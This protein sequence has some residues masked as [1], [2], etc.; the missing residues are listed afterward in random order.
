MNEP[1]SANEVAKACTAPSGPGCGPSA[2]TAFLRDQDW[3]ILSGK[4]T[5]GLSLSTEL[6]IKKE[7]IEDRIP[8]PSKKG[9]RKRKSRKKKRKKTRHKYL[10]RKRG[11]THCKRKK[12]R[13]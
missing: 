9:G 5:L 1:L 8:L 10:K 6:A 2:Y 4:Q 3:D 13:R 12:T 11:K 7:A